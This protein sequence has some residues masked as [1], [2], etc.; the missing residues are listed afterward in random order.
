[1]QYLF[2]NNGIIY[3][4]E[5]CSFNKYTEKELLKYAVGANLYMPATQSNIFPKMIDNPYRIGSMTL[6][7]EDSIRPEMLEEAEGCL[8]SLLDQLYQSIQSGQGGLVPLIFVRVRD[9]QQFQNFTKLLNKERL[10]VLCGFNFP[11]FNSENGR[12]YFETLKSLVDQYKEPLYGMPILEDE[13]V[14]HKETRYLELSQIQMILQE[15]N[16][17]VLNIRVGA[18]DFSSLFGLRRGVNTTIYEV[19]PVADCLTDILNYFLRNYGHYIISGPVW[20]YYSWDES[21]LEIKG[22]VRELERDM[23][24]GF[25]GKTIIHPSQ[26]LAVN[27]INVVKY[28]EYQDAKSILA[29]EGGVFAGYYGNKMNEVNPHRSWAEKIMSKAK[30][31]GIAHKKYTL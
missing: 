19:M 7:L 3:H 8:L 23:Q 24:C 31:F 16:D 10:S 27:K 2:D 11:K 13:R 5:P 28:D 29:A 20:E 14:M 9:Y 26:S 18:T 30:I 4:R 1:M 6:C 25:H 15:Y 22:L 17:Y 12:A 21:S